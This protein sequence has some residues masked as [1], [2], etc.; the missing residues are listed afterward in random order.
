MKSWLDVCEVRE[1]LASLVSQVENG[2]ESTL[3]LLAE[4]FRS[5]SLAAACEDRFRGVSGWVEGFLSRDRNDP[6]LELCTGLGRAEILIEGG[7]ERGGPARL[8]RRIRRM[9]T[10][11]YAERESGRIRRTLRSFAA[12]RKSGRFCQCS[13]S[14][15]RRWRHEQCEL[16]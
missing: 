11:R 1:S 13:C 14:R 15:L 9:T 7:K 8:A 5:W 6:S 10:R 3:P 2:E 12:S 4:T 16:R